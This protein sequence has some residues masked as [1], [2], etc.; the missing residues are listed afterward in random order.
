MWRNEIGRVHKARVV[1][2]SMAFRYIY[3]AAPLT[4]ASGAFNASLLLGKDAFGVS[5]IQGV[6]AAR[7]F[8]IFIKTPGPHTTNDPTNL[9]S[10]VGGK[11]TM[12]AAI[13]NKSS[14]VCVISTD[15]VVTSA[16]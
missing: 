7:G 8:E 11:M 10:T 6:N 12:T 1:T 4:T 13:L 9:F 16:S 15:R 14:A 3:S 5:E 2:S